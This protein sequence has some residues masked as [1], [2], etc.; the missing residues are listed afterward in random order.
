[1]AAISPV[2]LVFSSIDVAISLRVAPSTMAYGMCK[3]F[4][5]EGYLPSNILRPS[6]ALIGEV[7]IDFARIPRLG[8]TT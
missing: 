4:A 7:T 3:S 1:M 6:M 8:T 2:G 5:R